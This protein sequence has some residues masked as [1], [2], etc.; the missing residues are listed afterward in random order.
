MRP[1]CW[2]SRS[3][4]R[5]GRRHHALA[6]AADV[7]RDLLREVA[8]VDGLL[9][10]AVAADGEAR[11][12]IALGGDRDDGHAVER[13]LGAKAQRDLEAVEA[14]DVQVDEDDVRPLRDR[15]A[16]ALETVGGVDHLVTV[17]REELADEQPIA[18]VVL[19]VQHARHGR[20][21]ASTLPNGL[22]LRV[23]YAT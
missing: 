8:R 15:E 21:I 12:A 6:L 9:H 10:E 19:D 13:R 1:L 14:G 16:N 11:V 23:A 7:A 4:V 22:C 18:R 2:R 3:P 5:V 17:G 20:I